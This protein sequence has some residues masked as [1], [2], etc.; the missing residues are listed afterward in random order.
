MLQI[1][2]VCAAKRS[3]NLCFRDIGVV[4]TAKSA[5][6]GLQQAF[7]RFLSVRNTT[8]RGLREKRAILVV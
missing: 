8:K 5:Q 3:K 4:C 1:P 7:L 2:A 6:I